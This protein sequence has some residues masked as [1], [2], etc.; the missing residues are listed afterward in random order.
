MRS[1]TSIDSSPLKFQVQL[2]RNRFPVESL[3]CT[4]IS[5][6]LL[7]SSSGGKPRSTAENKK[8]CIAPGGPMNPLKTIKGTISAGV[9][10]AIVI[11]LIVALAGNGVRFNVPSLII[12]LHVL[13]GITWIGLLYYFNFV[14]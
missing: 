5:P 7:R 11:A 13:A 3:N 14:Q 12:W 9:V 4:A 8:L 6:I 1:F 10:L 2:R